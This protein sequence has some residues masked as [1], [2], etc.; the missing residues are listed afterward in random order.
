MN[1]D[2]VKDLSRLCIHTITTKPW[3][4][5]EAA[6]HYSASGVK[7][8]TVWRDAL[9]GRN[10]RETGDMLRDNGL[11]IVSLCRGGFFPGTSK[12]KRKA[13]ID[14]N[15]KAIEE[16][17]ELGTDKIVLVC[18]AEPSQSLKESRKQIFEGISSILTDAKAA[19]VKLAIEPLHPMYADTRSAINTLAQANDMAEK[20]DSKVVG[21]AVDVYHLWWDPDLK[22]EIMRCGKNKN[23]LA[24]HICDWKSPTIDLLNDRGLMG[25]GCIPIRKIRSWVEAAGFNGFIEVEIFSNIYWKQDQSEFLKKIVSAYKE[26]A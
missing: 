22:E 13:A 3:N 15:R 24:F 16:A 11:S 5:E 2:P 1:I 26:F 17:F 25:E 8:I 7:G 20:L 14:D 18:G 21:V 4:I 19:G 6:K 12:E 10:I 9:A 23:L